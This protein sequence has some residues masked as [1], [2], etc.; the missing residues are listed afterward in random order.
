MIDENLSLSENLA[1]TIDTQNRIKDSLAPVIEKQSQTQALL[2]PL[3]QALA[4][5]KT[6]ILFSNPA[7]EA[8]KQA[9][10]NSAIDS[11]KLEISTPAL[12]LIKQVNLSLSSMISDSIRD[13]LAN[14]TSLIGSFRTPALDWFRSFDFTPITEALRNLQIDPDIVKR[15]RELNEIYLQTMYETKWFPYAGWIANMSL[16]KEVN[17][18]IR[19]SRGASKNREKRIDKAILSYYTKAEIERIKKRWW[20]SELDYCIRKTLSQ[21]IGAYLRGEYA[22]TISCL[23]TMWEGLIYIKANDVPPSE[24]RR[25]RMEVTKQELKD[26]VE[27]NDYELIFS[28]YYNDF[29]V[30]NCNAVEDVVEGVPNRHGVAHSWYRKYPNKKAALNAILLTD[31]I[32]KLKPIEQ[33]EKEDS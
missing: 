23:C 5:Y 9:L 8:M 21:A 14:Y 20:N 29:I 11:I 3:S 16:F 17:D 6:N 12:D 22:L 32:V 30:S 33:T 13:V 4:S 15:H 28:D 10:K 2:S 27:Y 31:F 18:V 19:T 24:R 7:L 25:Q 1:K 26:L